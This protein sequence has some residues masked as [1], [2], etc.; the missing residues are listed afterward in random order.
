MEFSKDVLRLD[1]P[2]EADR[3]ASFIR[4][5]LQSMHRK[6][7][8]IGLSGGVDS[9]LAADL[10]VRA[11]GKDK[12][13]GLILPDKE[14]SLQSAEFA[15]KHAAA[16]GIETNLLD[17]TPFLEAFGTYEKRDAVA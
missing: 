6:G 17:I 15:S 16:L 10:S 13:L 12:V 3:I 14:S 9:A 4:D 2:A 5:Q 8:V 11:V 7:V 1:V